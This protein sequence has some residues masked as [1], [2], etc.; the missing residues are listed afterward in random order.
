MLADTPRMLRIIAALVLNTSPLLAADEKADEE[1]LLRF[2]VGKYV[3]IGREPDG[4]APYS[5]SATIEQTENGLVL[6][7]RRHEHEINATGRAEVPAPPGEGRVLRFRWRDP[8]PT[9]MTCLVG[10]DLDNYARLTCSWMHEG[11][12]PTE[13]GLEAMF[14]LAAWEGFRP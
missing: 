8:E 2:V 11:S 7:R 6:K 3:I 9:L 5:G 10:A 12:R 4:G 14:P 1:S 13:P